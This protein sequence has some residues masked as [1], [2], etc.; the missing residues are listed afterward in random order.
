MSEFII[1]NFYSC[2]SNKGWYIDVGNWRVTYG[3]NHK[4]PAYLMGYACTCPAYK[5]KKGDCK[6]IEQVRNKRCGWSQ[7]LDG[8]EPLDEDGTKLCP[9]CRNHI[10]V[11]SH[12]V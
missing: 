12:W 1:Q 4:D 9:N 11:Q 10:Y 2:N 6:H 7:F 3:P 5:Y 8:G